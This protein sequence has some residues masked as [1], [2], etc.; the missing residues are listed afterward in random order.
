MEKGGIVMGE[1]RA[2]KSPTEVGLRAGAEGS[3]VEELQRYLRRFGYLPIED[4]GVF[5][6]I[7]VTVPTADPI[8][9]KFDNVTIDALRAYQRFHGLPPTGELDAAT[10][11]HMAIPRCGFPDIVPAFNVQGRWPTTFLRYGFQN[12]TPDVPPWISA[13]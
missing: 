6:P 11:A 7:R 3:G 4:A 9:G 5:E 2:I 10:V 13:R 1:V 8:P 12:F